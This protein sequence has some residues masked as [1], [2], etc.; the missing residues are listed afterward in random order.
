MRLRVEMARM[1]A[2]VTNVGSSAWNPLPRREAVRVTATD[3]MGQ[4][5]VQMRSG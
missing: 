1:A 4:V 5:A 2:S 3:D